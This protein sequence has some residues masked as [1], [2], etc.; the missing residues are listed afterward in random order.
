MRWLLIRI[1]YNMSYSK[2]FLPEST[3]EVTKYFKNDFS[4]LHS[5][6]LQIK[7]LELLLENH[8]TSLITNLIENIKQNLNYLAIGIWEGCH[9]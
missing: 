7:S 1:I 9:L 8:V 6:I 3:W 4:T 2:I 5:Y